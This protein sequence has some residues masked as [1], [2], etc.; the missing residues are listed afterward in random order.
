MCKLFFSNF[1]HNYDEIPTIDLY[2]FIESIKIL[3]KQEPNLVLSYNLENN[4]IIFSK[5]WSIWINK[6]NFPFKKFISEFN[7][8]NI[9]DNIIQEIYFCKIPLKYHKMLFTFLEMEYSNS[10]T[11][12]K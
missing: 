4:T 8:V 9:D 2:P 3:N 1:N 11:Y 6:I 10:E 12:S 5:E 7:Q